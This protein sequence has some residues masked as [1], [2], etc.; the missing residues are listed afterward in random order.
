MTA[1]SHDNRSGSAAISGINQHTSVARFLNNPFDRSRFRTDDRN[2]PVGSYNIAK[3]NIE[4]AFDMEAAIPQII[5]SALYSCY[6]EFG[7]D[8]ATSKNPFL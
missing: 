2:D 6:E 3:A 8:I 4:A 1:V 5:E 7:W